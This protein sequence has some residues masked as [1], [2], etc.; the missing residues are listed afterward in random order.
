[1]GEGKRTRYMR[2]EKTFRRM[3]RW[4]WIGETEMNGRKAGHMNKEGA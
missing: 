2:T 4:R 1:M 3:K